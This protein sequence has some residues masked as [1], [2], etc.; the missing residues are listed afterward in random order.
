MPIF[1]DETQQ[2]DQP[3]T[4]LLYVNFTSSTVH[5]SVR[6]VE[7]HPRQIETGFTLAHD[8]MHL[9]QELI[10]TRRISTRCA[11]F[12]EQKNLLLGDSLWWST[13]AYG[14]VAR[15]ETRKNQSFGECLLQPSRDETTWQLLDS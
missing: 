9:L 15:A 2:R 14:R 3:E 1:R 10:L 11:G 6:S 5:V 4:V 8:D 12:V 7:I 13:S